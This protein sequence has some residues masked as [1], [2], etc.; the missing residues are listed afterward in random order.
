MSISLIVD[1]VFEDF[2]KN[3]YFSNFKF[4]AVF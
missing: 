3:E 1:F 4:Q 2:E